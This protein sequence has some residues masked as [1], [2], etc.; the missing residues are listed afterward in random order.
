MTFRLPLPA[1]ASVARVELKLQF[2]VIAPRFAEELFR[3]RTRQV[4][5]FEYLYRRADRRP[6]TMASASLDL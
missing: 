4:A 6:V 2:Q 1:G 5:I 3:V